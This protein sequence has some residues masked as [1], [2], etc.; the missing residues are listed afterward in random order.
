MKPPAPEQD[1]LQQQ[2]GILTDEVKVLRESV[3]ELK[4]SLEWAIKNARITIDFEDAAKPSMR[5]PPAIELFEIGDAVTFDLDGDECFGE[6]VELDDGENMATVQMIS[7][8]GT[9]EVNQDVLSRVQNDPLSY[10]NDALIAPPRER[11]IV[12]PS[13]ASAR[14]LF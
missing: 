10:R 1:D 13:A 8:D 2:I 5:C 7:S 9:I 11:K 12:G 3:D 6:I 14:L 4:T